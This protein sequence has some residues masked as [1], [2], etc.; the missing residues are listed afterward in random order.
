MRHC[1][2]PFFGLLLSAASCEQVGNKTTNKSQ[3]DAGTVRTIPA[4]ND[5][6]GVVISQSE[7]YFGTYIIHGRRRGGIYTDSTGTNYFNCYVTS[8]IVNDSTI[9]M[10]LKIAFSKEYYQSTPFNE[11]RFRVF[12]LPETMVEQGIYD[13]EVKKYLDLPLSLT[14]TIPPKEECILNIGFHCSTKSDTNFFNPIPFSLFVKGDIYQFSSIPDSAINQVKSVKNQLPLLL[15][16]GNWRKK[17]YCVIRC[18]Q[19]SFSN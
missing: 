15:G 14:K 12:L 9:P 7:K 17:C 19:I 3:A 16:L 5:N 2:I 6:N 18:G 8:R 4:T 10:H 11:Q 1:I 13:K